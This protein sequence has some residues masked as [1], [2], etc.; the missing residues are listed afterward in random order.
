MIPDPHSV[1]FNTLIQNSNTTSDMGKCPLTTSDMGK[2]WLVIFQ[3]G[4][5]LF[6]TV[7]CFGLFG[8]FGYEETSQG[9]KLL[10]SQ[11]WR[12]L[13]EHSKFTPPEA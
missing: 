1:S 8:L 3:Q 11:N 7:G 5:L 6:Q 9:M 13:R 10:H 2:F 12:G 4:G